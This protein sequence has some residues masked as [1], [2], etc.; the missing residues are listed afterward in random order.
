MPKPA[1]TTSNESASA[2]MNIVRRSMLFTILVSLL[3]S[4]RQKLPLDGWTTDPEELDYG[5]WAADDSE[6][7]LRARQAGLQ[8]AVAIMITT[9]ESGGYMTMFQSG[10]KFYFWNMVDC[11][12]WEVNASQD[13]ETVIQIM[14]T[15]GGRGLKLKEISEW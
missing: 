14:V 9:P 4:E 15:K 2:M 5:F 10:G 13:L 12:L 1:D 3:T 7:Q 8:R 11:G 6:G